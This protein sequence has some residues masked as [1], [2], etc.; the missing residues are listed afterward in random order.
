MKIGELAERIAALTALEVQL[1]DLRARCVV[2]DATGS[3]AILRA[4]GAAGGC[5]VAQNRVHASL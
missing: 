4:L 2:T 3:C 5:E 1:R